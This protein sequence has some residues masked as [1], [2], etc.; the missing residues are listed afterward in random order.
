VPL[1]LVT[2]PANSAKAGEVLGGL[3]ARLEEEPI[4][5]VPAFQDVEHSQRE[6]AE[7][8]AVFGARVQRFRW[9]FETVAERAG[10]GARVASDLQRELIAEEAIRRAELRVLAASSKQDGFAAAALRFV[11]E[12]ERTMIEPDR[13]GRA[14]E[15][16]AGSGPRRRYAD[17]VARIYQ[18]YRD[19]LEAAGLVDADLFAWRALDALR[20]EPSGWGRTPV[21]VYGFDDF[22]PLELDALETLAGRCEAQVTVSLPFEPGRTAF[23]AVAEVHTRLAGIADEKRPL[24]AVSDHYADES[25]P[26]LHHLERSLFEPIE[27]REEPRPALQLHSAGGERA[28]VELV[29]AEVLR[30]LREGTA[31]G[32]VAVVFRRPQDYA[33]LVEQ[34]FAAY[35]IPYS[36]DRSVPLG[37]TGLGRGLLA[38]LRCAVFPDPRAED[39]L[40]W[41]RA[42]GVLDVPGLADRLEAR[43]R[44][45]GARSAEQ[46]R[47]IWERD[48][49]PLEELDR[50]REARGVPDFL[51]ALDDAL[52]R[53]FW[54]PYR[55]RAAVLAGP[56]LDDPRAFRAAHEA[57]RELHAVIRADPNVELDHRRVHDTLADLSVHVG[58]DPQPDRVQVAA[59]GSIRA[60]RFEAVFV[61]GLQEGEFPSGARPE[62]FL[63]DEDR[64]QIAEAGGL[65]LPMREERLDRERYLFYVCASRAERML[66]LSSRYCDEDGDPQAE[67]F[68]VE[69]VRDLFEEIPAARRSLSDVTWTPEEA[70]TAA[71][72]ERSLALRGPRREESEPAPLTAEPLL[73]D[74]AEQEAVSAGALEHFADCPVKWLVED[75]LRPDA[76][77]PDPEAM[78]RGLYAHTV[79]KRT[80]ARLREQTGD[81]RVTREN[82]VEAERILIEELGAG[83]TEFQLSPDRTRV[84]AAARRLEFDLLRFLRREAEADG[85]FEPEHLELAFGMNGDEPV[86]IAEGV[87][88]RGRI[89]R[90]DVWD[91][92]ALVRDYKSGKSADTYKVA[93]WESKNRLQAPLYMLAVRE[94]L[95]LEPAGGVYVPLGN[96]KVQ[97]RGMVAGDVEQV[98]SGFNRNDR[99]TREEF[100]ARLEWAREQIAETAGRMR[101]GEL[102][103]N[104][105]TCA[106][107]GG[108]SYPSIC[109]TEE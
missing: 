103:C 83:T 26:A 35:G 68:F 85:E 53:L 56:Q 25:R 57:L 30:L 108:C 67:S 84:R 9:L 64:R 1:T 23:K 94:L 17:E 36:I 13:F 92:Y 14:L 78:V 69:D 29:G 63:P 58:E 16:W 48:H 77:E 65:V 2:G 43:V 41:L 54:R 91:R 38:L 73:N 6:L 19:G 50:L 15:E 71:E 75:V 4:L 22:T 96:D 28:E 98:G 5:V 20:R 107:N 97:A 76:L 42:P 18:G 33:S 74:L 10:Y 80:Y 106:W 47:A 104:P 52:K 31:P 87:R 32:D 45:E 79:L 100:D 93:S 99:L 8:G 72:Y 27:Q 12:L 102:R 51:V 81:R 49:W 11:S 37:H 55:R 7:R 60:R 82:L 105:E 90:V 101:R 89:D 3:R 44:R 61:C 88:V 95:G 109:R 24:D 86:E 70:P 59:P 40:A 46:A 62:P 66:V 39:L 21:F 34:V